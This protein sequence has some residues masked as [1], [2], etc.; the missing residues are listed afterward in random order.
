MTASLLP[1]AN[2]RD[3]LLIRSFG[4]R[5]KRLYYQAHLRFIRITFVSITS[6]ALIKQRRLESSGYKYVLSIYKG[7]FMLHGIIRS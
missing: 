3:D 4:V 7:T 5:L 1:F 2:L 6:T